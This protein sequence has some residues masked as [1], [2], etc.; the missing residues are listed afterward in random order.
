MTEHLDARERAELCDLFERLGPDAPTLCEGWTTSDLAAHLVIRE[1]DPRSAPGIM[2]GS[3]RIGGPF[4]RY[5]EKL[6]HR[7]KAAGY[8]SLV[9]TIRSGPPPFPWKIPKVRDFANLIEYFVHHEDVRRANGL[10]RRTDRPELDDALWR[11]LQ[12]TTRLVAGR[13][14]PV[15]LEIRQPDGITHVVRQASPM[16]VLTGDV[17]ELV[18]YLNG[19]K[20]AA[21]VDLSGPDEACKIVAGANM[22]I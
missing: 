11:L 6:Q 12:T 17:S 10:T 9:A 5:T 21:A 18:L 15:G 1:R 14:K 7:R 20:G 8:E 22:G 2:F 3:T 16:A 13:V 4:E 19:R